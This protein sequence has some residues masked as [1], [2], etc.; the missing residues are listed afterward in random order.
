MKKAF[1]IGVL[2]YLLI[3]PPWLNVQKVESIVARDYNV[4]WEGKVGGCGPIREFKDTK[5]I[6]FGFITSIRYA[7]GPVET[8]EEKKGSWHVIYV[9]PLGTTHGDYTSGI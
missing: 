5:R 7:C 2:L 3:R 4:R 6:M 9:S 1:V 8:E